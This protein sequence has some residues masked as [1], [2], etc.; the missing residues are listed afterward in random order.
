MNTQRNTVMSTS[1]IFSLLLICA[2]IF[3]ISCKGPKTNT[4][5]D[6]WFSSGEWLKGLE[7]K[8]HESTNQEAFEK[9]Y[10]SNPAL[11]D[12][13]FAWMKSTDLNTIE[14]GTYIIEE[15]NVRAIVS[16]AP[17]PELENVK[18]EAHQNFSDIQYIV[19]GKAQMGVAP[20]SEATVTIAYDSAN[21]IGFFDAEGE[22]YTAE[23]GTFFIFTPADAHRPG[24]QVEGYDTVKKVVLK[25]RA[26]NPA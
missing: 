18:W 17:A 8:A 20:V 2:G 15:D 22:Y 7:L 16:E 5:G 10:K 6:T 3:L 24:I 13:A 25:V 14:P 19:K 4:E 12:K 21:D 11:W 1:R 9:L 26:K 23:P